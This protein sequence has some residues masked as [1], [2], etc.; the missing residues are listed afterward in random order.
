MP[1]QMDFSL[2]NTGIKILVFKTNILS[3]KDVKRLEP[4][5]Q[6][7]AGVKRWSVD[8]KDIDKVLRIETEEL[9][10][11]EVIDLLTKVGYFCQELPD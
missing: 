10:A 6:E 3:K 9:Y 7:L 8:L 5:M 2:T 4:V 11:Q 1:V